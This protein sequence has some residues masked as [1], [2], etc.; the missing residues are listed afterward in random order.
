MVTKMLS[1]S[2]YIIAILFGFALIGAYTI[3]QPFLLSMIV[4]LLLTMATANLHTKIT[5]NL[6]SEKIS[7][8]LLS[9]LL[10]LILFVPII[11][12]AT[13]GVQALAS[14]DA[15]IIT[16]TTIKII[17]LVEGVPLLEDWSKEYLDNEKIL[18]NIKTSTATITK[19][20]SHGIGFI[21]NVFFVIVF[22]FI[23]NSYADKLFSLITSFLPMT[24]EEGNKIVKEISSTMEVVFYS[25]IV[26]AIFEGLLF[27]IVISFF[28]FNGL[29]FGT[30]YGFASLIPFVGG[31]LVWLPVSLYAWNT[32]NANSAIIIALYS[33]LVISILADTFIKPMI[34]KYIK[35]NILHSSTKINELLIFF[36]IVAGMSSYG[37]WGMILGPA[38][39]SFLI[40]ISKVYIELY[41]KN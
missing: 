1:K 14:I 13:T 4:A 3:Y 10:L 22:Y 39:T 11:Y 41:G 35:D 27:G 12:I 24:D 25:I 6:N 7:A 20:G 23:L 32:I 28:G 31:V 15:D 34:I 38:I 19:A 8:S 30:I 17:S 16:Q 40:A 26:T 9:L 18:E 2:D 29:L 33:I 21:K 36:S 5:Y 37:F